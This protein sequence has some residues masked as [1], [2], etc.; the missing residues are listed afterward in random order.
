MK[1]AHY[2]N[3]CW[4][5]YASSNHMFDLACNFLYAMNFSESTSC[6]R[7]S[8]V[9]FTIQI[10]H[11]DPVLRWT[12]F[13]PIISNLSETNTVWIFVNKIHTAEFSWKANSHSCVWN[14]L[15][16]M[17]PLCSLPYLQDPPLADILNQV[18]HFTFSQSVTLRH[19]LMYS[20]ISN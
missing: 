7:I 14:S 2:S 1:Y 16:V 15:H 3:S 8:T 17:K 9:R 5:V 11:G 10:V 4:F 20:S 13:W 18:N 12:H 6:T 19:I